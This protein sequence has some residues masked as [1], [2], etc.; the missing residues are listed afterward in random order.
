MNNFE[1]Y[2]PT[3]VVF[4]KSSIAKL[5][6]LI[7]KDKKVL[8]IY[9]GGSIKKNNVY[10]QVKD[11]LIGNEVVEFSGIEPNPVYETCMKAVD[12]VKK[13][14]IDFLLAVGGGSV[15]DAT[16]FIAAASK[17]DGEPWDIL[18]KLAP[19]K[20]ALPLGSVITLPATGSEMNGNSVISRASTNEKLAFMSEKVYPKFSIIDPEVTY[21]L[22]LKQTING[23]V[24]TYVHVMELYATFDVNT[25][26]Q[27]YWAFGL[28]KTLIEEAPKVIKNPEDYESRANIFWSATCGLN[29]WLALGCVQDWSTHMIGHELTAFYG[30]DHGQSLAIVLPRLWENQ[31]ASKVKKLA[32]L[33]REVFKSNEEDESIAADIAIAKTEEFF[34]SIGQ[35]TKLSDYNIDAEEAAAKIRERF[36][37]RNTIIGENGI[38]DGNVVYEIVKNC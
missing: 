38:I 36:L 17:F 7:D 10:N 1:F 33:A 8:L 20:E 37:N 9:G 28:I 16:K 14:N 19:I 6:N 22:P 24:D 32:K 5:G 11:A 18:S 21:S 13:E 27:D 3:R 34:N 23:I 29:Y 35:K 30:I 26:L 2:C 31:K 15:L 25:P 4:G 12:I